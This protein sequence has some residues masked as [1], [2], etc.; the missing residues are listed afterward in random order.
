M[1]HPSI[2]GLVSGALV[3]K[4]INRGDHQASGTTDV[5][6][7]LKAGNVEQGINN[8]LHNIPELVT[9]SSGQKTLLTSIGIAAGGAWVRKTLPNVKLG[10]S[11][12]FARI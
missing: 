6:A 4:A 5:L 12:I 1:P 9:T 2:T 11:K 3:L 10:G 7:A 8:L